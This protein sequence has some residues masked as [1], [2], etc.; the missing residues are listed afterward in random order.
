MK[1]SLL[2][3]LLLIRNIF[4]NIHETHFYIV[5]KKNIIYIF[6]FLK[7]KFVNI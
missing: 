1:E 2:L 7:D 5:N 4:I 3:L 6:D